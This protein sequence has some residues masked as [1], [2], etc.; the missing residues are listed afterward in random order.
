MSIRGT[1]TT[2]PKLLGAEALGSTPPS[3]PDLTV[4]IVSWNTRELLDACLRSLADGAAQRTIE[5]VVVDNAS[6]DGSPE[7][8]IAN[9]PGVKLIRNERNVG[10]A[11]ANNQSWTE[12]RGRYWMLLNSDTIVRPGALDH[13]LGFLERHPRAGLVSARLIN[14]D[15]TPQHCAQPTPNPL[16]SF[17]E[18]TRL[19]KLLPRRLRGRI[20]LGPYWNYAESTRV[21]WTWGTALVARREV[22]ESA[23]PLSEEFFMYGEDL[24]WCLRV[25]RCGWDVWFCAEADVV[26][27]GGQSAG[28][29]WSDAERT[30]VVLDATHQATVKRWGRPYACSVALASTL[31]FA[32][33]RLRE[34][35]RGRDGGNLGAITR[36]Q[37]H[38]FLH[39]LGPA[40]SDGSRDRK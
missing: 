20:F 16:L 15:G 26:H 17:W 5:V 8:V 21:G 19:H 6:S 10:F 9:Y 22:V 13:L 4:T 34:R 2:E 37:W 38:L 31:A 33:E 11:R 7:W 32:V 24:E 23:G 35:T 40:P 25:R 29:R 36:H 12:A 1:E 30:K 28:Q 18:M 3:S 27:Y 39:T 14:P